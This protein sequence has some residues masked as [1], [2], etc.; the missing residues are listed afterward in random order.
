MK[1]KTQAHR[2]PDSQRVSLEIA[3]SGQTP[4]DPVELFQAWFTDAAERGFAHPEAMSLATAT[5]E[6]VPSVRIVL[7]KEVDAQ[8][9]VFFT[10]YASR[11]GR[12]LSSNPVAALAFHW[13]EVERQVRVEGRVERLSPEESADYFHS[14]PR[15]SQIGAWASRQS[16]VLD[17]RADLEARVD[18]YTRRFEGAQV[19][20]P[21]H[22]GGFRVIPQRIEFWQGRQSRLH[23]R[24]IYESV[25]DDWETKRVYP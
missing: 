20:L 5:S 3:P 21:D 24:L 1:L 12:E 10:N 8:G 23:D 15:G 25:G 9:F 13:A 16:E 22:W 7:L 14:R 2:L 11:K 6:G 4:P 19:P 17:H 18:K